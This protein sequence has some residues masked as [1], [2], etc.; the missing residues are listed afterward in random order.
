MRP[1]SL[2]SPSIFSRRGPGCI[3]DDLRQSGAYVAPPCCLWKSTGN[4]RILFDAIL[5]GLRQCLQVSKQRLCVF[6][7]QA[8]MSH[9][10]G[11][12]SVTRRSPARGQCFSATR[13]SLYNFSF[14]YPLTVAGCWLLISQL[15][16]RGPNSGF[17]LSIPLRK[18]PTENREPTTSSTRDTPCPESPSG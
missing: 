6:G 7:L 17:E 15:W 1:I 4:E 12:I 16:S 8:S 2:S 11:T 9:V 14:P 10:L 13:S 18:L 3:P 5:L